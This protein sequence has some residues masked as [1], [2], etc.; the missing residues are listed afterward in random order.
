MES[1]IAWRS[2]GLRA[3]KACCCILHI[4]AWAF[5][6][7]GVT[8]MAGRSWKSRQCR[9]QGGQIEELKIY[10]HTGMKYSTG[11]G[12]GNTRIEHSCP[13]NTDNA[14]RITQFPDSSTYHEF[15][16]DVTQP[17]YVIQT[18]GKLM[19]CTA[20]HSNENKAHHHSAA[21]A[22]FRGPTGKPRQLH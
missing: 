2:R 5:L 16:Y 1:R 22:A 20:R 21:A 8:S 10:S 7:S 6:V 17:F 4:T 11:E 13:S 9:V 18:I 15:W 3:G 19:R 12:N 14:S